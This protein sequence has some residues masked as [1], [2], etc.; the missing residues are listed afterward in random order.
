MR[1]INVDTLEMQE[2]FEPTIPPY[3]ILSHRWGADNEEVS[4]SDITDG[5]TRKAGMAKLKGCCKQAKKDKLDY[6]WI[7]TCCI[8]KES[9]KELDEAINSMFQWYRRAS[10]CYT[11]MSDVPEG[12]DIWDPTSR[13]YSSSWFQRGWTLQE[14]LAPVDASFYNEE[15]NFIGTKADLSREIEDITGIPRKYLLGWADFHQASVAQRMS[16]AAKRETKRTEDIAYCLL[17]IFNISMSMIYGEKEKAFERLQLK[18]LEQTT[19][20]SILAWGWTETD[21]NGKSPEASNPISAGIFA[22]SPRDFA[23]CGHVVPHAQR[24]NHNSTLTVSGGYL[25]TSLRLKNNKNNKSYAMLNCC[26]ED[27]DSKV[28]AIPL[29]PASSANE[30]IR[31]QNQRPILVKTPSVEDPSQ[32][33][34]IKIDRQ[35]HP[36]P[37]AETSTWLHVEGYQKLE[38]KLAETYPPLEWKRS[39]ALLTKKDDDKSSTNTQLLR[40]TSDVPESYDLIVGIKMNSSN[41]ESPMRSYV[42]QAL[43]KLTMEDIEKSLEFMD[44]KS[45]EVNTTDNGVTEVAVTLTQETVPQGVVYLVSL[46][47]TNTVPTASDKVPAIITAKLKYDFMDALRKEHLTGSTER[48]ALDSLAALQDR[49]KSVEATMRAIE[50]EEKALADRKS[51]VLK[52]LE[53]LTDRIAAE[54]AQIQG[55][56]ESYRKFKRDR[57]KTQSILDGESVYFPNCPTN[58]SLFLLVKEDVVHGPG[59]WFEKIIQRRL[60]RVS[61]TSLLWPVEVEQDMKNKD[62]PLLVWAAANKKADI[63]EILL[64]KGS[65]IKV[66]DKNGCTALCVTNN[67]QI[68]EILLNH[69][70]QLETRNLRNN[71]PLICAARG[72]WKKKVAFLLKKGAD[73]EARNSLKNTALASA[74]LGGDLGVI[75]LLLD[76][77]A[78]A[79]S[80]NDCGDTP[81]AIAAIKGRK[82]TTTRLL[83][84]G[85]KIE[86]RN[87]NQETPLA[88]A[89]ING[90]L[91]TTK[92]LLKN[93]A[94]IEARDKDE[95][96]PLACAV[97]KGNVEVVEVLLEEGADIEVRDVD[98][99]S[100]LALAAMDGSESIVKLLLEKDANVNSRDLKR[101]TALWHAASL[102]HESIIKMLSN[103]GAK[104]DVQG[105]TQLS[106]L[107]VAQQNEHKGTVKLLKKL[108]KE[109]PPRGS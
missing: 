94:D 85:A 63:V 7:D 22:S 68:T 90:R 6:V 70:A 56:P 34:Q 89:A 41:S 64:E 67:T 26:S 100:P 17:G 92:L 88:L 61:E 12:D 9:S 58:Q 82:R 101:V 98:G 37:T 75:G 4:F 14:L 43:R 51:L 54:E 59:N 57:L 105:R 79:E 86:S 15:W 47:S 91:E 52:D 29:H 71:T 48:P 13:F 8:N 60:E 55:R 65:D 95:R 35:V 53:S 50:E 31:P 81:L 46:E 24:S 38:L 30:Y 20:D 104:L 102:G 11:Y 77:G 99:R 97:M 18:I 78:D 106:P 84:K 28:I 80:K 76:K 93:G 36:L 21:T 23:C 107:M 109:T 33:L 19:D 44:P 66:K 1:L 10:V 69:G 5:L 72:G 103:E 45:L 27:D 16:W 96:T 73:I 25:H 108:L 3:A 39:R 42:I 74:V 40:F 2:F 32:N 87:N 49:R 62:Q 83:A